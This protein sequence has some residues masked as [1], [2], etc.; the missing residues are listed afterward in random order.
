MLQVY[1]LLFESSAC[2][3]VVGISE[4]F[5][6]F[7]FIFIV[8]TIGKAANSSLFSNSSFHYG[9]WSFSNGCIYLGDDDKLGKTANSSPFS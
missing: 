2:T 6:D 8:T 9:K 1:E 7:H 3:A 5:A 4:Q